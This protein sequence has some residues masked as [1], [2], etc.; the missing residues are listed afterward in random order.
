MPILIEFFGVKSF[1]YY[2]IR[3]LLVER[4]DKAGILYAIQDIPQLD[5][6]IAE[7]IDAVPAIRVNHVRQFIKTEDITSGQLVTEVM[8]YVDA[9][10]EEISGIPEI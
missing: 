6:F 3:E 9:C 7:K 4:L 5:A 2:L 1:E 8:K 10:E